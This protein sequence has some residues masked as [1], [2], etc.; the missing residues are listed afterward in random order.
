MPLVSI[1]LPVK[2]AS[3]WIEECLDSIAVQ[4][5]TNWEC[6]LVNDHSTDNSEQHISVYAFF[7]GRF[8]PVQNSGTGLID[9]YRTGLASSKGKIITRMDADDLMTPQRLEMMVN[10]LQSAAEPA[11][12]TGKVSFFPEEKIGIGTRFYENW[13]NERIEKSDHRKWMWRECVIPSPCWMMWRHDLENAGGFEGL[14]YPEDYDLM[15]RL[16]AEGYRVTGVNE[17]L[18]LW[19]QH[20]QRYSK[21]S[22]LYSAERFMAMKWKWFQARG[23][24]SQNALFVLGTGAKSRLLIQLL[25]KSGCAFTWVTHEKNVAGN[26]FSGHQAVWLQNIDFPSHAVVISTLSSIDDFEEVYRGIAPEIP[27]YRFC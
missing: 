27:V 11:V 22:D 6:I 4:T 23:I 26:R 19:R 18:H 7:D 25:N 2:N 20:D 5:F 10:T 14:E 17:V 8:K 21:T 1:I 12:I 3:D 16:L 24:K 13:L 9:A 15:F